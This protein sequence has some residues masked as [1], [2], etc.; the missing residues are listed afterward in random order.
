MTTLS[1]SRSMV[2]VRFLKTIQVG[3]NSPQVARH[4]KMEE[5]V[6]KDK[7]YAEFALRGFLMC[8][9]VEHPA[10]LGGVNC[11]ICLFFKLDRRKNPRNNNLTSKQ[12][13]INKDPY[14]HDD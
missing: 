11:T 14:K 10:H 7:K 2:L 3:E 4:F 12:R 13:C 1:T 9:P 5:R 8:M 6:K